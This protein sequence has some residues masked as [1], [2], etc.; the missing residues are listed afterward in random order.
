MKIRSITLFID[1]TQ[2]ERDLPR[3]SETLR[4]IRTALETHAYPVETVRLATTPFPQWL[5]V[6]DPKASAAIVQALEEEARAN[7]IDFVSIGPADSDHL[8]AAALIPHI[9]AATS[10]VF[11]TSHLLTPDGQVSMPA[12]HTAAEVIAANSTIEANGFGNLRYTALAGVHPGSPFFPAAYHAGERPA[13]ALAVDGAS[14]AVDVFSAAESLDAAA[15]QLQAAIEKHAG[16]L[17]KYALK[18]AGGLQFLGVDFTLA[19]YPE[20]SRSIGHALELLGLPAFGRAGSLTASAY[21]MSIL[22]RANFQRTGFNGLMLPVLEDNILADRAAQ[23]QLSI[24]KLLL[25]SAVCGTGLDCIPL[26]GNTRPTDLAAVLMDVAALSARLKKQLTARLMPIPGKQAGEMTT[27]DFAYFANSRILPA[28]SGGL[29]GL[30]A[31]AEKIAI[32]PRVV[33]LE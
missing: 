20:Q 3:L 4:V 15:G 19:P 16:E 30:F 18:F 6:I 2:S 28:E 17:K 11:C 8:Q 14:L 27:F 23:G 31:S 10:A 32:L 9:L 13:F 22:D 25:Y 5:E 1:P 29:S 24:Q 21:L 12:I 7:G 33:G 26:P